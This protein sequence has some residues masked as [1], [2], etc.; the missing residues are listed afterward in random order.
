[1]P[2]TIHPPI[3][4]NTEPVVEP[5]GVDWKVAA[6]GSL[7]VI[8]ADTAPVSEFASGQWGWVEKT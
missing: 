2:V 3:T 1:M 5:R 8:D 4:T 6:G 7:Q